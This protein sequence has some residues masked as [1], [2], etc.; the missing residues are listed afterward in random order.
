MYTPLSGTVVFYEFSI[1]FLIQF[2][3]TQSNQGCSA[4]WDSVPG[5]HSHCGLYVLAAPAVARGG[6]LLVQH[7]VEQEFRLGSILDSTTDKE[8]M[9]YHV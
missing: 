1:Y 6:S 2:C 9:I 4:G 8:M 5:S 3:L 7:S